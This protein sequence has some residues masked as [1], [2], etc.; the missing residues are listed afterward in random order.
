M[1]TTADNKIK[2]MFE[3]GVHYGYKKSRRHPSSEPFIYGKKDGVE[4]FNLEET[5]RKLEEAKEYAQSVIA[6]GKD[7]LFVASK[8]E[9][10]RI[11]QEA[12]ERVNQPYMVG[13]WIGG[14]LTN[15]SQIK[16][17]VDRYHKLI[18][19]R[20]KGE[21]DKYTKKE[22]LILDREVRKLEDKFGGI[23][24]MEGLPKAL[25]IIDANE[26]SLA[27]KEAR[28]KGVEI[29]ALCNN[30]CDFNVVD[31]PIP[32]NDASRS[33]IEYVV[34]EIT[35]VINDTKQKDGGN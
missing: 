4:I 6:E 23:V 24:D 8:P 28:M 34:G 17:R 5:Q 2:S 20:E 32:G 21:L 19:Q 15:Y 35:N 22:Q 13:R 1:P 33:S 16:K 18:A 7:I 11:V 12:A 30:D 26:E 14:T 25:F 10:A 31:Y 9:A 27:V 3:A 29:I